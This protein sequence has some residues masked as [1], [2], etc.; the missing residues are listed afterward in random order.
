MDNM[1][2][3]IKKAIWTETLS[4]ETYWFNVKNAKVGTF[5][6]AFNNDK[7]NNLIDELWDYWVDQCGMK[8]WEFR[9]WA[10]HRSLT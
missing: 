6:E 2:D 5:S 9:F 7:N 1:D 8:P 4:L 3:F 10:G